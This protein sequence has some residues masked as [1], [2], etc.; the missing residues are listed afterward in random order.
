MAVGGDVVAGA[1][2]DD[3]S[4]LEFADGDF[5]FLI[6]RQPT[7][8]GRGQLDERLDGSPGT[9]GRASLDDLTQQH[10]EGNDAGGLESAGEARALALHAVIARDR[11]GQDT[12]GN[13]LINGEQ[14]FPEVFEGHHHDGGA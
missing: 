12:Q 14:A 5:D 11:A 2:A 10:E 9:G 6:S 3:V 8:L 13:Q 1:D 4:D 7:G